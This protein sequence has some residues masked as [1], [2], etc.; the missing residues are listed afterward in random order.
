[1][2]QVKSENFDDA[3]ILVTG[4]AGFVGS[5]LVKHLLA[6]SR[7]KSVVVIDNYLSSEPTNLPVDSRLKV[8]VG[9]AADPRVIERLPQH[10]DFVFHL[11][12]YHGNQSSIHDPLAD[13][14]H[15]S[16]PSLCLF[17]ALSKRDEIRKVVYSAAG[18]AVAAKTFDEPA[19]TS[20]DAP[21]SLFHDSPYSI[22]KL[23]GEMYGNYY[24]SRFGM[25]FVKARF[26]NVYGPGEVLGAGQWR[27][28]SDTIWRNV[29]PNFVWRSINNEPIPIQNGGQSTRDF[30]YVADVVRGLVLCALRG[31]PG[32]SYNLGSGKETRILDLAELI[33]AHSESGSRLAVDSQA[34]DWDKSGRRFADISKS[35]RELGFIAETSIEAGLQN[36]I[37]WTRENFEVI[38]SSIAKH[39]SHSKE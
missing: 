32:E 14:D 31:V 36:T 22:S 30:I 19:A 16:Y 3:V 25:P 24:F 17:D 33:V 21:V 7:A 28:T 34:R 18:C 2:S 20:E 11:A 6:N 4:G 38:E 10:I 15:N 27:G 5:N 23:I 29:V 12:C 9:S 1:M 8:L 35:K 39:L 37:R 13:H 26:Q